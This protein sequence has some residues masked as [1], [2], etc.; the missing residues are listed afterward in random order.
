[1]SASSGDAHPFPIYNARVRLVV[2]ILDADGD[3]VTGAA[4]L[5]TEL[6]QDQ[7]TFTDATNEATEIATSSGVYYIDLVAGELDAKS[8]AGIVKTGTA[9]A[10]TTTFVLYP[11]RLPVIRTGTAQAGA[12]STITLDS[13]ASPVDD[14]YNGCYVNCTNNSPAN[15][16]GQARRI[17][18]YVGSTKVATVEAAWG[19]NPSSATTFEILAPGDTVNVAQWAGSSTPPDSSGV[20]SLLER[21]VALSVATGSV[22]TDGGNS[23]TSFETSLAQTT[24]DYWKDAYLVLTSGVLSGQVK[25]VTGYNGTTKIITVAGGF[26]ATPADGVTF[27]IINR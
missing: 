6:S 25:R 16:Q 11:K 9:G 24:N 27:A 10:K 8:T 14:F 1:M 5:D 18:D 12:G 4:S 26:T 19:T 22:T 23:A 3:L 20:T 17:T 7:G 21:I 15:V 2:P 13:G